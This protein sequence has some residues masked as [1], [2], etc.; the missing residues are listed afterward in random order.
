MNNT[1]CWLEIGIFD[2]WI[3]LSIEFGVVEQQYILA[4]VMPNDKKKYCYYNFI[5]VE[6]NKEPRISP[7]L[8]RGTLNLKEYVFQYLMCGQPS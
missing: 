3:I 7:V 8:R 1:R 6:L 2:Y 5:P 4:V